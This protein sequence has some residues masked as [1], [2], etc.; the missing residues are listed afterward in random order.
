MRH[1][2]DL[3]DKKQIEKI[4]GIGIEKMWEMWKNIIDGIGIIIEN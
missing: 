4:N 3:Y 2:D 1:E